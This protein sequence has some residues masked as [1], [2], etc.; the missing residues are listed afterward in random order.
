[1]YTFNTQTDSCF[2]SVAK[3]KKKK[4]KKWLKVSIPETNYRK[5]SLNFVSLFLF[6]FQ[7]SKQG[8]QQERDHV[9]SE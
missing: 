9:F 2:E 6:F 1:M 7:A 8:N 4:K 5:Y 3:K